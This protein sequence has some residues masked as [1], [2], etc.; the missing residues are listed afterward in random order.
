MVEEGTP[1]ELSIDIYCHPDHL[2]T[3]APEYRTIGEYLRHLRIT[4]A[5]DRA[6]VVKLGSVTADI[7]DIDAG[8]LKQE[9]GNDG[10]RYYVLNFDI[11]MKCF[12]AKI[13]FTPVLLYEWGGMKRYPPM[14]IR[15]D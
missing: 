4:A 8:L 5:N 1:K 9:T 12:A 7:R 10:Q 13:E 15:Y 3:G 14:K 11:E 6:G 2:N